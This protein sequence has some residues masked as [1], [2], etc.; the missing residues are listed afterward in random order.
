VASAGAVQVLHFESQAAQVVP[1][2]AY[3]VVHA[4]HAVA[5]AATVQ[6]LH[7]ESQ[8]AQ[9]VPVKPYPVVHAVH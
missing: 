7:F 3:P 9:V 6:A 1:V 8:A 5:S 4:E 2:K